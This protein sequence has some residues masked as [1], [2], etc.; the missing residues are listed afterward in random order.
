MRIHKEYCGDFGWR[1]S[2]RLMGAAVLI[3]MGLA[4]LAGPFSRSQAAALSPQAIPTYSL[5]PGAPASPQPHAFPTLTDFWNGA[6]QW[7][8]DVPNTGLPIGESDTIYM[9][10]G[11]LWSYLHASTQSAG[12]SDTCGGPVKFPGCVTRWISTDGGRHFTL[13]APTCILRC[14]FCPC[15]EEDLTRQQQYPR[16]ARSPVGMFY[17]VFEHDAQTWLTTS[18]DG[19]DWT[20]PHVNTKTGLWK[21]SDG[22]CSL[23]MAIGPHPAVATNYQCMAGGPP[24]ILISGDR[25][26]EFV[27][28][29]QNPGHMGCYWVWLSDIYNYF[30]CSANP[31]FSGATNY[32][33]LDA[34]G[35]DANPYFDFRYMT[36]ADVIRDG[37]YYYM[38]YEGVRGP[39]SPQVGG[40]DQF[41]LGFARSPIVSGPWEK[42]S[43]N[44]ALQ[45][46]A[47]NWGVGHADIVVVDGVTT[48]YTATPW[49]SRGRYVLTYK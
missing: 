36:S 16:V 14:T 11:V 1:A 43:A 5:P 12:I 2:I 23:A 38:A 39:S 3:A 37:N 31:L 49:L 15:A 47:D 41:A 21:L 28:L 13:N 6:A 45:D 20:R 40:D 48:M 19:I 34:R 7:V 10:N 42:Y 26:F 8:L 30:P 33:P 4:L 25:L 35:L 17:M 32:G 18:F 22:P 9:G 46:V 29:G 24:G 44:P 27:G